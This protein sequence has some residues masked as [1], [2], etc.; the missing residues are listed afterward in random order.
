MTGVAILL[1][2]SNEFVVMRHYR[3]LGADVVT[4]LGVRASEITVQLVA[5][6]IGGSRRRTGAW[7]RRSP[8]GRP[9]RTAPA[10]HRAAG[11]SL[12]SALLNDRQASSD[13]GSRMNASRAKPLGRQ[14]SDST[15]TSL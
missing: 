1:L 5:E 12:F 13:R 15:N 7:A 4:E 14:R 11:L 8:C 3:Q 2:T 9:R 10:Q 6:V